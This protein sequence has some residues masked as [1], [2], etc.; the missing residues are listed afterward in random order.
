MAQ[1]YEAGTGKINQMKITP[2]K[3]QLAVLKHLASWAKRPAGPYI[4]MGGYAGTGKTT[5]ISWFRQVIKRMYPKYKVA[6]CAYTGKATRVLKNYLKEHTVLE[7]KDSV[8][9]IHSLIYA[10][11]MDNK[12]HITGWNRKGS[13]KADLIILDEASMVDEGIWDDL[14][15][16]QLPIVAVGDHGQLPPVQGTFNLMEQPE[17]RLETIHR[18]AAENPIIR[19]SE[20]ARKN[21]T[22]PVGDYGSGVRKLNRY[23]SATGQEVEEILRR[24]NSDQLVLVGFN[25][26]RVIL[27][28]QIRT[29]L[30]YSTDKPQVGDTLICL[31]NNWE[32]GIYN[33][34]VG[35][36]MRII[37]VQ[38]KRRVA[39]YEIE[40]DFEADGHFYEGIV[41]AE[42]FNQHKTLKDVGRAKSTM[43]LFDFG[44]ALTVHK[45]QGSEAREVLLFEERSQH[46]SDDE[47]RR[48]LYTGITR[49]QERL[50]IV[51]T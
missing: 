50:T 30:D 25:H 9:T 16:F 1:V 14:L 3:E 38:K 48:W 43:D 42:Q 47:W 35:R 49:A 2:S 23:D 51:G 27:N 10:P 6:F 8:S 33:G 19:L 21:G 26:S 45:A 18:Q 5:L 39:A 24:H 28:K 34:M 13:I 37:P 12:G 20:M 4:T 31:K 36:L 29:Y 41:S 17:L 32:K 15:S 11:M 44:Y 22:V 40:M 46:M 7:P